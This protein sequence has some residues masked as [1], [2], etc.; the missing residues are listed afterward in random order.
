MLNVAVARKYARALFDASLKAGIAERVNTDLESLTTLG[1]EDPAFLKFLVAPQIPTEPKQEFIGIVFEPKLHALVTSFLRLLV[2]KG[3]IVNLPLICREFKELSEENR[4]ILR[5][6]VV[7]VVDLT[8]EQEKRLV[9]ELT[10]LSGQQ[11][12]L[13]KRIDPGILGGVILH[14]GDKIV[15]R[16]IRRGLKTMSDALLASRRN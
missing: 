8:G 6:G 2:D 3:R 16:S 1:D 13:E 14:Y 12:I 9:Q 15:D 7:T 5:V 11:V 10:T 4:G